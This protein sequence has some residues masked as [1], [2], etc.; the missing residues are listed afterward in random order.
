M[1]FNILSS[2]IGM[3]FPNAAGSFNELSQCDLIIE[4][5]IE[6]L[7]VKSEIFKRLDKIVKPS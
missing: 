6:E 7:D 4:S 1:M 3:R 5:V 2:G